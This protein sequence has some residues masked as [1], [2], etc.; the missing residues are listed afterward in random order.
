MELSGRELRVLRL[1]AR[2]MTV[3]E[4]AAKMRCS[5]DTVKTYETRVRHKLG[6]KNAANAVAI[7]YREG[8]F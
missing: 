3:D 8:I 1:M 2:G 6:A 4:I 7:A 5:R